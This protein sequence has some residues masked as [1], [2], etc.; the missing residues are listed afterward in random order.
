[1]HFD[2]SLGIK[3]NI[4]KLFKERNLQKNEIRV[5]K[6]EADSNQTEMDELVL[7]HEERI[8]LLEVGE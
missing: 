1:M 4:D 7:D 5:N 8:I 3:G 6:Q 2:Y